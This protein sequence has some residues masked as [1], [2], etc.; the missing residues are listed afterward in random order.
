M[1]L[2]GQNNGPPNTIHYSRALIHSL[3]LLA[4][5][6]CGQFV[7]F[8]GLAEEQFV[9]AS[10]ERVPEERHWVKVDVRVGTLGLVRAGAV[11]VPD[12]AFCKPNQ[13]CYNLIALFI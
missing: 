9:L 13:L 7:V 5:L 3:N 6:T 12:G 8:E 1:I 4:R 11:K 10:P 2:K